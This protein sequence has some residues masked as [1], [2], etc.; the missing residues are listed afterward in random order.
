MSSRSSRRR[1][2]RLGAGLVSIALALAAAGLV[3]ADTGKSSALNVSMNGLSIQVSGTWTWPS[4]AANGQLHYSGFAIDWGD[5]AT[6]NQVG[7]FHIGDGTPA[8]NIVMQPTTP[9]RGTSGSWGPVGHTYAKGGTYTACVI[10]YDI[11]TVKPFKTTGYHSLQAGGPG[12]NVDNAVEHGNTAGAVC[13]TF[14][15]DRGHPGPNADP[16]PVGPRC[17]CHAGPGLDPDPVPVRPGRYRSAGRECASHRNQL[18]IHPARQ[19]RAGSPTRT[20]CTVVPVRR[21]RLQ[22]R[23]GRETPLSRKLSLVLDASS[24]DP[25]NSRPRALRVQAM[26]QAAARPAVQKGVSVTPGWPVPGEWQSRC[27]R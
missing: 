20:S 17:H 18:R 2:T 14:A 24:A 19:R 11:G 26:T 25:P 16:G 22:A 5:V 8:T 4:N 1:V 21:G 23:A 3:N 12:H 10:M 13:A 6:G 27:P 7:T 9:D 15:V